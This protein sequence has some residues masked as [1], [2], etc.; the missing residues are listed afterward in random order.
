MTKLTEMVKEGVREALSERTLPA[1]VEDQIK[2]D[3][4]RRE[5]REEIDSLLETLPKDSTTYLKL[6]KVRP[7]PSGIEKPEFKTEIRGLLDIDDL[8]IHI[9]NLIKDN[10]WGPGEYSIR[11]A[12]IEPNGR[13]TFRGKRG[14]AIDYTTP[15]KQESSVIY[16]PQET[17]TEKINQVKSVVESVKTLS[18]TSAQ[19]QIDLA[20][21]S[22][23]MVD[24]IKTGVEIAKPNQPVDRGN[25][26]DTLIKTVQVLKELGFKT[27]EPSK[28]QPLDIISVL[29][30]LKELGVIGQ[31]EEKRVDIWTEIAKMRELGLIPG[32]EKR[33]DPIDSVAKLKTLIDVITP[34]ISPASEKPSLGVE[35]IR[36][37]GPHI[38]DFIGAINNV[39]DA[40]RTVRGGSPPPYIPPSIPRQATQQPA[41]LP[42]RTVQLPVDPTWKEIYSAVMNDDKSFYPRIRE[43]MI[44][45]TGPDTLT[46][47]LDGRV[48]IETFL[49]SASSKGGDFLKSDRA[50]KYFIEFLEWTKQ[51][52]PP[53]S[54]ISPILGTSAKCLKCNQ[55]FDFENREE[56]EKDSKVCDCGGALELQE[57]S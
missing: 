24:A 43:L 37:I 46:Y 40:A 44:L 33:E 13:K 8:E 3:E 14:F 17:L 57:E 30:V 56:F 36:S 7:L 10:N 26:Q 41:N 6:Y 53:A 29:T 12:A 2:D 20:S 23:T 9:R 35:I 22:R 16:P 27:P 51:G 42:P 31:K 39:A 48:S 21:L 38:P 55:V 5:Q 1:E 52:Q 54:G 19:P 50:V 49:L 32:H 15:L 11:A 28:D 34:I 18:P 25:G 45:Y 4:V 47:L